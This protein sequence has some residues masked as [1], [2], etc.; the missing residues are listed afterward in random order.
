[1][2]YAAYSHFSPSSLLLI[3]RLLHMQVILSV[4][5]ERTTA[6]PAMELIKCTKSL[7]SFLV[8]SYK[9]IIYVKFKLSYGKGWP[10]RDKLSTLSSSQCNGKVEK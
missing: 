1:M 6:S 10:E 2:L 5:H 8:C 9:S 4:E 7:S 3:H